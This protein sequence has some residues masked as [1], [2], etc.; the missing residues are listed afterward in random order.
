MKLI[1]FSKEFRKASTVLQGTATF[2][3]MRRQ[4]AAPPRQVS[5][6]AP[7]FAQLPESKT[8]PVHDE[9][10]NAKAYK[11]LKKLGAGSFGTVFLVVHRM[12]GKKLVM[13]EVPCR[14]LSISAA[15]RQVEE[16]NCLK[17]LHHP[18]LIEYHASYLEESTLSLY[19]FMEFAE[20][21]DLDTRIKRQAK[22]RPACPFPEL[23][24]LKW[25]AQSLLALEYCHH[26]LK[27]LHRDIKPANLLLTQEDDI[28]IGDFG[29]SKSLTASHMQAQTQC[30]TPLYMS[31]EL[32]QGL[33]YDRGADIWALGCTLYHVMALKPPWTDQASPY[34]CPRPCSPATLVC[35]ARLTRL[36]YGSLFQP[37]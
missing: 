34:I 25:A 13:K 15:V 29:M 12:T 18:H 37:Y 11:K 26:H 5:F 31:P 24:V 1:K 33:A 27:L 36:T 16:I 8:S 32:C 6:D 21:G 17:K 20:G 10:E 35:W 9:P 3:A 2:S 22:I 30:G 7:A 23:V 14:G 19:M 28:K 4:P